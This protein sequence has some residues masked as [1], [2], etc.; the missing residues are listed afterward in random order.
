MEGRGAVRWLVSG[1]LEDWLVG[2]W[3]LD[4]EGEKRFAE[5]E[6]LMGWGRRW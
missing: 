6:E 4:S 3:G 1:V 2:C 5:E